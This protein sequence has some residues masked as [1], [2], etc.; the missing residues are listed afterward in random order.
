MR[1]KDSKLNIETQ[2]FPS[3]PKMDMVRKI[4]TEFKFTY[5][6]LAEYEIYLKRKNQKKHLKDNKERIKLYTSGTKL[7]RNNLRTVTAYKTALVMLENLDWNG[8]VT[9]SQRDIG[10]E[11]NIEASNV[12]KAIKEILEPGPENQPLFV[13]LDTKKGTTSKYR[14]NE[15]L[16]WKGWIDKKPS[17]QKTS[18]QYLN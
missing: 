1:K 11:L 8:T 14:I 5:E 15:N 6:E 16:A 4:Y 7:L 2:E 17:M 10:K 3:D 9:I 12:N 18:S 13:K